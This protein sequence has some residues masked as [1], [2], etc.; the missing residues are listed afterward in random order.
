MFQVLRWVGVP[1]FKIHLE[2]RSVSL[3]TDSLQ[4][5]YSE[6]LLLKGVLPQKWQEP[7]LSSPRHVPHAPWDSI[8]PL[9]ESNPDLGAPRPSWRGSWNNLEVSSSTSQ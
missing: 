4:T 3:E 8:S 2:E 9:P 1:Q 5:Y 7:G 6:W